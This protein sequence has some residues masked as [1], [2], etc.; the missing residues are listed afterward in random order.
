MITKSRS[1][2][3]KSLNFPAAESF[4]PR[5]PLGSGGWGLRYQ[6]PPVIYNIAEIT[7]FDKGFGS[8]ASLDFFPPNPLKK[9]EIERR[10]LQ[11]FDR[12]PRKI[13]VPGLAIASHQPCRGHHYYLAVRKILL[14]NFS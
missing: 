6:T 5:P 14:T 9:V 8:G 2:A 13:F 12:G 3:N 10:R 11:C 4:A 7:N 1:F